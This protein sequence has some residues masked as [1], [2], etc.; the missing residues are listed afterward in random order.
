MSKREIIDHI[1]KINRTAPGEFLARFS[2]D[3]L[4]A[5]LH[6]LQEV[7]HEKTASIGKREP[8][9]LVP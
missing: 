9:V 8:A 3:E 2:D 1:Q 4:L 7:V 5:Y 6:Q